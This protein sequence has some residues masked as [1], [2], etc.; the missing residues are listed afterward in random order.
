MGSG[1]PTIPAHLR[2]S[3]LFPT[4]TGRQLGP[5]TLTTAAHSHRGF[6]VAGQLREVLRFIS[7]KRVRVQHSMLNQR[8]SPALNRLGAIRSAFPLRHQR[9]CSFVLASGGEE[10]GQNSHQRSRGLGIRGEWRFTAVRRVNR[11][12]ITSESTEYLI[13][14]PECLARHGAVDKERLDIAGGQIT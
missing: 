2:Q 3:T 7:A 5:R 12:L 1:A 4:F 9:C 11:R 8:L 10:I 14:L 13:R 6:G